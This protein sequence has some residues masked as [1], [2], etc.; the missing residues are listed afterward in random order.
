MMERLN[1]ASADTTCVP[2]ETRSLEQRDHGDDCE[3]ET[4]TSEREREREET[5]AQ[6]ITIMPVNVAIITMTYF[7]FSLH[8]CSVGDHR[9]KQV[10]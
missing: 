5:E 9:N 8:Q 10:Y 6:V 1:A 4:Q 3:I 7:A 2:Y